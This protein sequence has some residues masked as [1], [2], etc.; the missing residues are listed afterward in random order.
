MNDLILLAALLDGPKH[1]WVLK[2][3]GRWM[4]GSGEMHNNL[5]YPA[6][7]KFVTNE[8]VKRRSEAGE[9]GQTR[10]VY[11]LTSGGRRELF[12]RLS[13]FGEK[14]SASVS[15]F[16]LRV[17]LFEILNEEGRSRVLAERAKWLVARE[18]HFG[19]LRKNLQVTHPT[20]WGLEV[21]NY[22]LDDVRAER[23]WIARLERKAAE[24]PYR[25]LSKG[26]A[27]RR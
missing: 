21:V 9:R 1:G 26:K 3:L 8:W 24:N 15:E 10:A 27:R 12:R 18:K 2:K 11:A 22:L 7:K 17:G 23:K 25:E 19:L 13:E 4:T 14:E 5:V 20:A 16:R 6:M